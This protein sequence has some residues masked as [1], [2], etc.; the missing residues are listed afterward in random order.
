MTNSKWVT[1][2]ILVPVF[3]LLTRALYF[4]PW[5]LAWLGFVSGT[6]AAICAIVSVTNFHDYRRDQVVLYLERRQNALAHTHDVAQ[7]EAARGVSPESVKMLINEHQRVW[8]LRSGVADRGISPH[9]VMYGAPD[10][11][12]FFVQYFLESST[13]TSVMPK[14]LL[15]DKRKN[16]FDPWGAVTEYEMY[17]HLI[18]LLLREGKVHRWSEFDAYEWVHPWTPELVAVSYGWEWKK[19]NNDETAEAVE[20]QS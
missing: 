12:E 10:V 13:E 1:P 6:A 15:S 16:R 17:D 2:A 9:T 7:L 18:A 3:L 4:A 5:G 20:S 14:R 8:M 19:S 11:T